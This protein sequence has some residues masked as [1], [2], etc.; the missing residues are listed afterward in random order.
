MHTAIQ[1]PEFRVWLSLFTWNMWWR[2]KH[3]HVV[4]NFQKASKKK[5]I[6]DNSMKKIIAMDF[7]ETTGILLDSCWLK[8]QRQDNQCQSLPQ[9]SGWME[10]LFKER[11]WDSSTLISSS[12]RTMW[13]PTQPRWP[14]AQAVQIE[15]I[16]ASITK[17][18]HHTYKFPSCWTSL[19]V[20]NWTAI[21]KGQW[22]YCCYRDDKL[23]SCTWWWFLCFDAQISH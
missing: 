15:S 6:T 20:F 23:A 1:W 10:A 21:P 14:M 22:C 17:S 12:F 11:G 19:K 16:A 4:Q 2:R 3:F 9:H 7:W 13:H 8:L 5:F 18:R